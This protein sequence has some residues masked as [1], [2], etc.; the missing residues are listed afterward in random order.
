MRAYGVRYGI[1]SSY[2]DTMF[3]YRKKVEGF[4]VLYHSRKYSY[5]EITPLHFY[6]WFLL[7]LERSEDFQL[8]LKDIETENISDVFKNRKNMPKAGLAIE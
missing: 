8:K 2:Y 4:N 6:A 7:C 5:E 1:V 3:Y